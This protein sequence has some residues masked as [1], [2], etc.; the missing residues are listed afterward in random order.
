MLGF[1]MEPIDN[2]LG[3]MY[4]EPCR[5]VSPHCYSFVIYVFTL[6]TTA[7]VLSWSRSSTQGSITATSC[8][9]AAYLQR[10]VLQ[11]VLNAAVR[12]VFRLRHSPRV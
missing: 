12:L 1:S 5:A 3:A 9:S 8:L 2:D 11:A 10:L 6:P 7:F 4:V